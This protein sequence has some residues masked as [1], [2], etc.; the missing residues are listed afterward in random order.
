[1]PE[2]LNIGLVGYKFMGKAHSNAY[3]SVAKFFGAKLDPTM[4]A[5]CGR[6]EAAVREFADQWGWESIETDWRQLVARD[7][8][9]LVDIGSPGDTHAEIAIAAAKA[10]KHVFCEKPLA[11]SLEDCKRMVAAV[12]STGVR[13]MIN[14]NYRKAPAVALA[15]QMIDAGEIGEVRHVRATYLQDWLVDPDF[16]MNWRLRKETAGSG[17]LGDL[18]AH[19]VD[20]ARFLAGNIAEVVGDMKTFITER[21]A[22]GDASGLAASAGQGVEGVTVDDCAVFLAR[23]ANGAVGTFEATRLA[24]GRKNHNRIEVSGSRGSLAW[25]FEDLN[26]LDVYRCDDPTG[27]QGFRRIIATEGEHPY[28]G[29]WWPPGHMLGYDHTFVNAVADLIEGVATGENP[30]PCFLAGANCVSVLESVER[31]VETGKWEA[32]EQVN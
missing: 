19:S 2:T 26:Y 6:N 1:M 3:L 4:K 13:H 17:A 12:R 24:A 8:I 21:P 9:H 32:V 28:A 22:E 29:A 31:S 20:L 11:N 10:G 18:A 5:V 27:A 16:P 15:K 7:D 14:F 23:F 25:C 30:S